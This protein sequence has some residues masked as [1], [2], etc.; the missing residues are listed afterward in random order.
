MKEELIIMKQKS[1]IPA[2]DLHPPE[3]KNEPGWRHRLALRTVR[4]T[5]YLMP[6]GVAKKSLVASD[7][8]CHFEATQDDNHQA[9]VE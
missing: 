7:L 3:V 8:R 9:N 6:L 2:R 5:L 1:T 4:L